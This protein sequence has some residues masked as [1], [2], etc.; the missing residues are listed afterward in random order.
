MKNIS[1]I[2]I[3]LLV[4]SLTLPIFSA[5]AA[6]EAPDKEELRGVW[7]ATVANIDY[8]SKPTADSAVL[9][10]EALKILDDAEAMG[11]NA[12]FLQ[13]RPASD[14]LY[15]SKLFPWSKYLT[16][17]QGLAPDNAFDPLK[18]WVAEAH[19]RGMEL[20]AWINPYRIT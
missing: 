7:V 20:H 15:K 3:F 11:L 16:G 5:S 9:K 13:V 14:A 4:L 8:P 2:L 1:R 17:S 12:I 18:F 19:K 10:S 6:L